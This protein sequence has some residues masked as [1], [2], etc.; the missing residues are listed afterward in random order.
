M[1]NAFDKIFKLTAKV[2]VSFVP[3]GAKY[4]Q[5]LWNLG[6]NKDWNHELKYLTL[7]GVLN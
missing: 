7:K 3:F 6:W 1:L 5:I 4:M 2:S